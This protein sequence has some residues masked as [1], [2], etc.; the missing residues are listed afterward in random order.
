MASPGDR[1]FLLMFL[2]QPVLHFINSLQTPK[3]RSFRGYAELSTKKIAIIII[4][5]EIK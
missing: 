5:K 1:G 2:P 4:I 3:S